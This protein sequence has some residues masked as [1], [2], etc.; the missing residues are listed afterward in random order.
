MRK[1]WRIEITEQMNLLSSLIVPI[2][3]ISDNNIESF[4]KMLISKYLLEDEQI[5]SSMVKERTLRYHNNMEFN[6]QSFKL[7]NGDYGINYFVQN[8]KSIT[9]I[10]VNEEDLTKSEKN[11]ISSSSSLK[12]K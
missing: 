7:S 12:F 4:L 11:K 8:G 5:L 9:M 10:L 6:R 3:Q 2:G 1:F